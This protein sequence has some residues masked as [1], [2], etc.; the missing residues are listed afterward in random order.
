MRDVNIQYLTVLSYYCEEC[1][2]FGIGLEKH[3]KFVSALR[4]V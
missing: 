2:Y 4:N 3:I 1:Q